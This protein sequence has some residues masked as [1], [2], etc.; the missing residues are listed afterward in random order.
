MV[1]AI[2]ISTLIYVCFRLILGLSLA[3]GPWGF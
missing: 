3:K 1:C 2:A